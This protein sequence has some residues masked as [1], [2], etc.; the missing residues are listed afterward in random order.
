[1]LS[2]IATWS[3]FSYIQNILNVFEGASW[4]A[5]WRHFWLSICLMLLKGLPEVNLNSF[6]SRWSCAGR[7][8]ELVRF[9]VPPGQ[10]YNSLLWPWHCISRDEVMWPWESCARQ[11][12]PLG[13]DK[14][15]WLSFWSVVVHGDHRAALREQWKFSIDS[16]NPFELRCRRSTAAA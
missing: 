15:G 10:G 7:N 5:S 11:V 14:R 2:W 6:W 13:L 4:I 3:H 16:C 12:L 8:L 1:M 9:L